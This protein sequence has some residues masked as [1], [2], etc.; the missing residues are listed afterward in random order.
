MK[1]Y[2]EQGKSKKFIV[3]ESLKA[4]NN[5]FFAFILG[6]GGFGTLSISLF[7]TLTIFSSKTESKSK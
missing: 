3:R 2:K 7:D 4:R 6:A 5:G 1:Y